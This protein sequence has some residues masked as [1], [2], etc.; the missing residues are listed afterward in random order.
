MYEERNTPLLYAVHTAGSL[1]ELNIRSKRCFLDC[2]K[3]KRDDIRPLQIF[4][5]NLAQARHTMARGAW[6]QDG[7]SSM[8]PH[9]CCKRRMLYFPIFPWSPPGLTCGLGDHH[10][11]VHPCYILL[12]LLS[13]NLELTFLSILIL[14]F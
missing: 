13:C 6:L 14:R 5:W 12:F 11:L 10:C 7:V 1:Q 4:P 8:G 3:G 2:P 9:M